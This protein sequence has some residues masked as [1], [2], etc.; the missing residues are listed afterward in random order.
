MTAQFT[1]KGV[2]SHMRFKWKGTACSINQRSTLGKRKIK[3]GKVV[4]VIIKSAKYRK[5]CEDLDMAFAGQWQEFYAGRTITSRV[6]LFVK[7]SRGTRKNHQFL[8]IDAV[9]KPM[10]DALEHSQALLNDNLVLAPIF[11]PIEPLKT[12]ED[13]LEVIVLELDQSWGFTAKIS[14]D[15]HSNP[16]TNQS[17]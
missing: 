12:P 4:S 17:T 2:K 3:G 1:L 8:D 7:F 16:D 5:F 11:A 9:I 14:Q 10:Q 15:P 6:V 13:I